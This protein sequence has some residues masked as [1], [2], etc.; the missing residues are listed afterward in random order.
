MCKQDYEKR[1]IRRDLVFRLAAL[2]IAF[3]MQ[4]AAFRSVRFMSTQ[5]VIQATL[6]F[7]FS[8]SLSCVF[9]GYGTL[10]HRAE[11][12]GRLWRKYVLPWR[13]AAVLYLALTAVQFTRPQVRIEGQV[14][15]LNS[16]RHYVTLQLFRYPLHPMEPEG[17]LDTYNY[18]YRGYLSD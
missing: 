2:V 5:P 13:V 12:D 4:G 11:T 15:W 18:T 16:V 1:A 3:T 9:I 10:P 7:V 17:Y 6:F 14:A 8:A